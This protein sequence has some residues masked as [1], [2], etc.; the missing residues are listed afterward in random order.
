[1]P[2]GVRRAR[3][4]ANKAPTACPQGGPIRAHFWP[5]FRG[6]FAVRKFARKGP[7]RPRR[8]GRKTVQLRVPSLWFFGPRLYLAFGRTR[9]GQRHSYDPSCRANSRP[10]HR[11]GSG[12]A[13]VG[14][15]R[16]RT[17]KPARRVRPAPVSRADDNA[18]FA[19]YPVRSPRCWEVAF[20]PRATSSLGRALSRPACAMSAGLRIR[21]RAFG[22]CCPTSVGRLAPPDARTCAVCAGRRRPVGR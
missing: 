19:A 20:G 3:R 21:A 18:L 22:G 4:E 8:T 1:M 10:R 12:G 9:C 5:A 2:A 11:P 13:P 6:V 14:R 15:V 17:G 16:G 7:L